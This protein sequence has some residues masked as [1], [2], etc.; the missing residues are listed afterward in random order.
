MWSSLYRIVIIL[1]PLVSAITQLC[2]L[3]SRKDTPNRVEAR[4]VAAS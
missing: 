2:N 3:G 1:L 4:N